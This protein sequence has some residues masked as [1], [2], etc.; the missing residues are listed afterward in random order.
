MKTITLFMGVSGSGKTTN[1]HL[2][3]EFLEQFCG[4]HP[5]VCSA[6][7]YFEDETGE[8]IYDPKYIIQAHK[9]CQRVVA[10]AMRRDLPVI[11]HNTFMQR[12]ERQPYFRMADEY[13]Y[14][15]NEYVCTGKFKNVHNVPDESIERQHARWEDPKK[16]K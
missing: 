16:E 1:A 3:S 14:T 7:D 12:W 8:Y 11:V 5:I 13:G 2:L 4:V 15:V 10:G 9:E 6:D